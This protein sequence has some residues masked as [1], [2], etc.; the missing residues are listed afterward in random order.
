[1][2][3]IPRPCDRGAGLSSQFSRWRPALSEGRLDL[4]SDPRTSLLA[5]PITIQ[6][7]AW[8]GA[9]ARIGP[10]VTIGRE[11]V[12]TLGSVLL[13]DAQPRG[14]YRGNPATLVRHRTLR[15]RPGPS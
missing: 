14:I 9:F 15:D 10:G 4:D 11:A 2:Y 6:D 8:V 12:V 5:E 7:C 13:T 1:M 3:S